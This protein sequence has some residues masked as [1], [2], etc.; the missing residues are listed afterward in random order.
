VHLHLY[1]AG[2]EAFNK[3]VQYLGWLENEGHP[4]LLDAS[5]TTS[6]RSEWPL[7]RE[8]VPSPKLEVVSTT[9]QFTG[10]IIPVDNVTVTNLL[11]TASLHRWRFPGPAKFR[12]TQFPSRS[13]F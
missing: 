12:Q 8:T 2:D 4:R 7:S 9:C 13:R 6:Q 1:Q 5:L 3:K 10:S 11:T